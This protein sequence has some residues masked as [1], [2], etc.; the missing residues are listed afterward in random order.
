MSARATIFCFGKGI[1]KLERFFKRRDSAVRGYSGEMAKKRGGGPTSET[2]KA[3][4]SRNAI[5][6][7][8]QA[9]KTRIL[10]DERQEDFDHIANGWKE[11][12]EPEG[13]MEERLVE[14]LIEND[15]MLRRTMRR[16]QETEP[17][18]H[19]FDLILRYKTTAERSFYRSLNAVQQLRKDRV[20]MDKILRDM[21]KDLQAKQA[22]L[23]KR[24]PAATQSR[25]N[26]KAVAPLTKAQQLFRGQKHPKKNKKIPVLDQWIEIEI[27]DGKTVTKLYPS[28][29]ELI[30]AGQ[31]M[32]PPPEMVYRRL[33]F[34]HGVPSE[35]YWATRNPLARE[36]GGMGTQRMTVD[37]W[38][39]VIEQEKASGTGHIG[40]C[41]GNL[42]RPEER[43][44]CDC[45]VCTH[46]RRVLEA[47]EGGG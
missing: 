31:A 39:D 33:H 27:Q 44:G 12:Y 15:W 30:K 43:G 17:G 4:S 7:G 32:L 25:E 13:Y 8:C 26:A 19:D 34:V 14:I 10:A 6:N 23:D 38:L 21:N 20:R 1:R 41:G 47:R 28:N 24:P 5:T 9:R 18:T 36:I 2:G 11:E 42:P 45:E 46:N 16:L 3:N 35:Y 37:T 29:E 22:E 40:P